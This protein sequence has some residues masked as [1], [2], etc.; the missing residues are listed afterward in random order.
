MSNLT[1]HFWRQKVR[2]FHLV[3]VKRSAE[4]FFFPA[5]SLC[6]SLGPP[7]AWCSLQS[8]S[9]ASC[10]VLKTIPFCRALFPLSC[11]D[12]PLPYCPGTVMHMTHSLWWSGI[13]VHLHE[14]AQ[15]SVGKAA[16][17]HGQGP[18]RTG[19]CQAPHLMKPG[20]HP[21]GYQQWNLVS[22]RKGDYIWELTA[23]RVSVTAG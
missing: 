1:T 17:W 10:S 21:F 16:G 20:H 3:T 11:C 9:L 2:H 22:K 14:I 7:A 23:Q 6:W 18:S 4:C 13:V 5:C 8:I 15:L 12:H 19:I